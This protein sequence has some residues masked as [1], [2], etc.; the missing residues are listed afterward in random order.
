MSFPRAD[1]MLI[2]EEGS[3]KKKNEK[4]HKHIAPKLANKLLPLSVIK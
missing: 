2:N 3:H 4:N 1:E